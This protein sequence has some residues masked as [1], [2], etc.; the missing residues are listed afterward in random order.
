MPVKNLVVSIGG[1]AV[2]ANPEDCLITYALGSCIGIAIYDPVC[3]VG[4]LLH[5]LLPDSKIDAEKARRNPY[6]FADTGIPA[7]FH[8]AYEAGAEKRRL[9]VIVAGGAQ[10]L[11]SE[12]FKIGKRNEL[13]MKK[14]FWQAGVLISRQ[15]TGGEESR[16]MRLEVSSGRAFLRTGGRAEQEISLP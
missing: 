2:T 3:R 12:L 5:Y 4:G 8:L 6:M 9:R 10:V 1:C 14:I 7:L 15:E 16:T 11:A 13:A